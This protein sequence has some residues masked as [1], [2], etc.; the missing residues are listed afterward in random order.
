[1]KG[2]KGAE[3]R[4]WASHEDLRG[5]VKEVGE[6]LGLRAETKIDDY[7][8][9]AVF[10]R[11]GKPFPVAVV[12]ISVGGNP[13]KDLAGLEHASSSHGSI[14]IYVVSGEDDMRRPRARY[15]RLPRDRGQKYS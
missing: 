13:S 11:F 12:E 2:A 8:Y 9:N 10:F 15:E 5:K 4:P 6:A 14:P 3:A 1:M 7:R